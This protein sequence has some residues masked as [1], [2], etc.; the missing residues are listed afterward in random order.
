M[1]KQL[2]HLILFLLV[3]VSIPST[4]T[5]QTVAIPDPNL[6]AA[7]ETALG[8]ASGVPITVGEMATLTRLEAR[9]N[10]IQILTGLEYATKLIVLDLGG[11]RI[12]NISPV[13]GLT[14][15][16]ELWLWSNSI[17]DISAVV[18]LINLRRLHLGGN[19]IS[20][21]LPV[22]GLTNLTELWLWSNSISD[23][24][25]VVGLTNLRWLHLGGNHI[26][27]ISPVAR[28]TN[29]TGL[30]LVDNRISNISPV[31]RLASLTWLG[32]N[33]NNISN[34]LPLIGLTELMQLW[35]VGNRISDLSP[36]V[37]NPG[38][39]E[40]DI[41]DVTQNSLNN[42]SIHTHVPTLQSRGVTVGVNELTSEDIP[43]P[44]LRAVIETALGKAPG[45]PI[46]VGEMATLTR[47]VA[48]NANIQMLTG[49][50]HATG[51][52]GLN[53]GDNSISDLS[54]LAG[55][56][57]LAVLDLGSNSISDLSLVIR[58]T[59][60]TWLGLNNNS[61]LDLSPL[62]ENP[63]LGAGDIVDVTQNPLNNASIHT[64]IRT[65]QSRGVTI[66]F[67]APKPTT[68]EH[69]LSIPA[70]TSLI[71]IPLKVTTVD[72]VAQTITSIADLYDALGGAAVVNLLITYDSTIQG[73][74]I[75]FGPQDK[76][77]SA[78]KPLT[79]DTGII[80][81]MRAPVTL[82][83]G[84]DAFDTNGTSTITLNQGTNLVG[85]L[86]KD[87]RIT[88]VSDLFTLDGIG[89][90]VPA[91]I[92]SDNGTLKTVRQVDDDGDIPVTEGQ[93]FILTASAP[94]TVAI[95]ESGLTAQKV[96][97]PTLPVTDE[98]LQSSSESKTTPQTEPAPVTDETVVDI[99]ESLVE[100][101]QRASLESTSQ[102]VDFVFI[103]DWKVIGK[104][105][106]RLQRWMADMASVF[107]ESIIDYR[108][109]FVL[110]QGDA[111]E[112]RGKP[113]EK[114]L[115]ML[116]RS[117]NKSPLKFMRFKGVVAR[118]GLDAIMTGLTELTFRWEA[119]RHFR[120]GEK[121]FVVMTYETLTTD[122]ETGR[123]NE[124]VEKIVD[125]C[126]RDEIQINVL[127]IDEE[128]QRQLADL[129]NG[130]WYKISEH[131]RK[132]T[133]VRTALFVPF[134]PTIHKVFKHIAQHIAETV[135][136]PIDLVFVFDS[137]LSMD[138]KVDAICTEL[139]T[140]VKIL[141]SEGLDY[142]FGVIRFWAPGGGKSSVTITRPPLNTEQVRQLFRRPKLGSEH[143]LDAIMEGVSKLQT[144]DDRKLVLF[145]VTDELASSG[146]NTGY[147]NTQAIAVCRHAGAQV[148]I[149][150]GVAPLGAKTGRFIDA[151]KFQR[152]LAEVTNGKLYIMPGVVPS[153]RDQHT[154]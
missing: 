10:S 72:G 37:E 1:T 136:Q 133:H 29:L 138:S 77:K 118:Y 46:T 120:A 51:L 84:G 34:L 44:N 146:P 21:I 52:T 135:E 129:T 147:T 110:F 20:N 25:A 114:R 40:G 69:L 92:V 103:I 101:A 30:N 39:G 48:E 14:N 63:G 99:G 83:L 13:A 137:S 43:D 126:R 134:L 65:L 91:I 50:E 70:G 6:R 85:V 121:H 49:L 127:G 36:L 57:N 74:R 56:T 128:I 8:K 66:Q 90:N 116:E 32:L 93:A 42:V 64:H 111:S 71:H 79:G 109:A 35:L 4:V 87:S 18:G 33:N 67:D 28:L 117:M 60:L 9:K 119:E 89:D 19:S 58:L 102:I 144:P 131:E 106:E 81:V 104:Q 41:V 100:I 125:W 26:S 27:D 108:I 122:W 15:L 150:G 17:S 153:G 142:R 61:I 76:G 86:L 151:D 98:T 132:A 45:A 115:I 16:T 96:T 2:F 5:A 75:Y 53:L 139:D 145:V 105:T 149:I 124:V 47:L 94:A 141:D 59:N 97:E 82:R 113:L 143:L 88:R 148:N 23:I 62:A 24:S 140:L 3:Y 22:A 55:L 7:V 152:D 38:L 112:V 78:D 73:W 95:S 80:A 54:P 154:R 11:N 12:S 107:D 68:L 123:E 130:K 31:A